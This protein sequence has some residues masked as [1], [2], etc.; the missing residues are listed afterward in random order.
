[1][2]VLPGHY[3]FKPDTW[4]T[5]HQGLRNSPSTKATFDA[6]VVGMDKYVQGQGS[7]K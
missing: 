7:L 4:I 5:M 2:R 1:V 6:L 3:S